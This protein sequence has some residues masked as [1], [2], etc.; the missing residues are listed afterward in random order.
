MNKIEVLKTILLICCLGVFIQC[1]SKEA[2][3]EKPNILLII[4]DD[5]GYADYSAYGGVDDAITPN[6]DKIANAGVRFTNAYATAPVC[7]ASRAGIITGNYQERWGTY[8]YGGKMFSDSVKTIPELLKNEGYRTVKIGKT[9][10]VEILDNNVNIPDPTSLREFPLNHGYDEFMGFCAHRHDYFKLKR[11][12]HIAKDPTDDRMSQYGPLWVNKEQKDFDGYL[13]EIFAEEAIKQIHK[14]D[15]RPFFMELSFNAVH[16]PIY[17]APEKYLKKFGIEKFPDWDPEKESFMDYHARTCWKGEIDP[18]GRKRYLANLACL[19]DNIGYVIDALK[20]S[21]KWENTLV[22]FVSDNGG[23]QNTYADNG[24]LNG[25]KYILS[26]GGIRTPFTMSWPKK[27]KEGQVL[28]QPM[29]H[30]DI[31]PTVLAASNSTGMDTIAVD[32]KNLLKW[33]EDNPNDEIHKELVW[34]TGNEWAVRQ[35]NWKLHI[36]KKD[37]HFRSI[38]LDKGTYLYNLEKD[39][40]EKDNLA[41]SELKKV[42]ELKE[43]YKLWKANIEKN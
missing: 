42:E 15:E 37:N 3:T 1:K 2:T 5:Q 40:G 20:T 4:T 9:H 21:E 7:N 34:D 11:S 32:G 16:H 30:L 38:H 26:E 41:T 19:D 6:M 39:P 31:L 22:I 36:V 23:S 27:I 8:Y 12:D 10:Y 25:H 17:Q 18:D 13:T 35:G 28:N 29:S 33:I 24:I 43:I 14:K